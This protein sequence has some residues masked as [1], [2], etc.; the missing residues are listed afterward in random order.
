MALELFEGTFDG[1]V[2][3]NKSKVTSNAIDYI[4]C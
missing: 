3:G 2:L 1:A 4:C